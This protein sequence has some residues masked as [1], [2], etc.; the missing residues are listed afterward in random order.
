MYVIFFFTSVSEL[1]RSLGVTRKKKTEVLTAPLFTLHAS[2]PLCCYQKRK[3]ARF[4]WSFCFDIDVQQPTAQRLFGLLQKNVAMAFYKPRPHSRT[5]KKSESCNLRDK[6]KMSEMCLVARN[7]P[8]LYV[9]E[10]VDGG[11]K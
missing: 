2:S 3:K 7:T 6:A 11:G 9:R 4:R 1:T 5:S 10:N 8:A